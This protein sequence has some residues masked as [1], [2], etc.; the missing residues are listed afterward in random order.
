MQPD[1]PKV[2]RPIRAA[3]RII[4]RN[5]SACSL[6]LAATFILLTLTFLFLTLGA[7]SSVIPSASAMTRVGGWLGLATALA[8]WYASFAGVTNATFKRTVVPTWPLAT[9]GGRA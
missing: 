9:T 1:S 5:V 8:A 3:L 2:K 4:F 6:L 7:F